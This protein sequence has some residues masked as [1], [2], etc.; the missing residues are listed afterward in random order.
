MP[1][2]LYL[3]TEDWAFC[4]HFLPM[5]R[6]A[7]AAGL[8]VVV[9]ARVGAEAGRIAAE[10][11]R[12]IHLENRRS[13][14]G[15]FEILRSMGRM[16]EVVRAERPDIVHCVNIRMAVLGGIA[17]R[18]AGARTVILAP[19]GLGHLWIENGLVERVARGLTR[20]VVGRILRRPGTH[21]LFENAE[22][23]R[24]LGLDPADADVTI[25]GGA[26]VDPAA[27]SP[28]PEPA[29]PPVTVAIVSR[30]LKPKGIGEA[31]AATRRARALGAPV[32]LH[33]FGTPD[34]G[35][36][37]SYDDADLRRWTAEPGVVWHG[38]T[39][40]PAAVYRDHHVAMLLS[41]REGLPK[42]LVEAAA[43]GRPIV[44]TDVVGCREVVRDGIEGLLVP[45]GDVE[46][47]ARALVRLAADQGLRTLL[48]RA[49]RARF[50]ARFTEQAVQATMAGLYRRL[51]PV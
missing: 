20:L 25:V 24:E 22:D 23:P 51:A 48:G 45:C 32:E 11:F 21:Y 41:Y 4:L 6:A 9:A 38:R 50:E 31:V 49:A 47:T 19:T 13:S 12:L 43:I 30:M 39:D 33:L 5:A 34:P 35:N 46:A 8:E 28:T 18:F 40:D 10:G 2:L 29:A 27:F 44:A 36:R 42:A 7:K 26:G 37:M 16:A 3:A 14:L 1:K 15:P 17:A